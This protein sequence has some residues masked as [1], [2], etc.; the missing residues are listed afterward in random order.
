MTSAFKPLLASIKKG[1]KN[2]GLLGRLPFSRGA[3]S[4]IG[5]V[6]GGGEAAAKEG[7]G[8]RRVMDIVLDVKV[9]KEWGQSFWL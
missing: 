2:G 6:G 7:K 5:L 3:A 4:G 1:K 8:F 9:R